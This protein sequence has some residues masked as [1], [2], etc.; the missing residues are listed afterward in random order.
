[1]IYTS[2]EIL[3]GGDIMARAKIRLDGLAG[4]PPICVCCGEPATRM[5]QQEFQVNPALSAAILITAALFDALVWT[6]RG[7]TLSLPVCEYHKR[8][9]RQANRTFFGGMALTVTLGVAAY[10]GSLFDR[11]AGNY[12]GVAAMIAFVAM[13][14]VGMHEV[15]DG[16]GVKSLQSDSFNLSGVHPKFAEAVERRQQAL[17]PG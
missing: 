8:R 11:A 6:K 1:V 14:L 7:L 17:R 13:I 3:A 9:G 10:F 15:D 16:L 12:L 2:T 4:L 5:R